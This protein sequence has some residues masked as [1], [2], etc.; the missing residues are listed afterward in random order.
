MS[1][2]QGPVA[3]HAGSLGYLNEVEVSL[4]GKVAEGVNEF[5]VERPNY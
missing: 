5:V 3:V 1:K 4:C 2:S